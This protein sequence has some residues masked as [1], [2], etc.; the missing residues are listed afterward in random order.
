M[1]EQLKR[2][3]T[4]LP[5]NRAGAGAILSLAVLVALAVVLNVA[6]GR[7]IHWDI[8]AVLGG[9]GFGGLTLAFRYVR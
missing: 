5:W 4:P 2:D 1:A 3:R 6:I 9:V 7:T 8:V